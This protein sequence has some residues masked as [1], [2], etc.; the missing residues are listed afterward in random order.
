[1]VSTGSRS[2]S[3]RLFICEDWNCSDWAARAVIYSLLS[4]NINVSITR[5]LAA[6]ELAALGSTDF[7]HNMT[8]F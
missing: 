3:G 8:A 2:R 1:M 4:K 6:F 5:L 7:D